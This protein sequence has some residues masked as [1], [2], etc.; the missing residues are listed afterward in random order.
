MLTI[1]PKGRG[2]TSRQKDYA[3]AAEIECPMQFRRNGRDFILKRGGS[4]PRMEFTRHQPTAWPGPA[5]HHQHAQ[6]LS[7][8]QRSRSQPVRARPD[9][10]DV[11]LFSRCR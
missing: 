2:A 4:E 3:S 7:G 9:N 11:A 1:A 6:T 8:D 5:L 10:R